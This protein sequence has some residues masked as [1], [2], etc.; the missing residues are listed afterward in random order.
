MS[1]FYAPVLLLM[2]LPP[3]A[4]LLSIDRRRVIAALKLGAPIACG[5]ALYFAYN[6]WRFGNPL[7]TGYADIDFPSGMMRERIQAHGLWSF[8][9]APFNFF[10]L[11]LQGFHAD[12]AEPRRIELTGMDTAG[13]SVL[14]ASPWLLYLL[15]APPRRDVFACLALIL[16]LGVALLFYHSN[17]FLQFNTQRYALD[18][19]P[20]ALVMLA[21]AL[22]RA[23]GELFGP[24]VLWGMALN[25]ATVAVM[26][27]TKSG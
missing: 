25:L 15:F 14:A 2:A 20:A 9:Y 6:Y 16:G 24:L 22:G 7:D 3:D 10:Y 23:K 27:V 5:L 11:L 21:A 17:G 19:L 18:W 8:A 1:I 4:P 26:A 13:S 12:F